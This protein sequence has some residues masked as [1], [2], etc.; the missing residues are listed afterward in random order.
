MPDRMPLRVL[1]MGSH[2]TLSTGPLKILLH[3]GVRIC[4]LIMA[5][6]PSRRQ[7]IDIN[8]VLPEL[9][10]PGTFA[11]S[12]EENPV[13]IAHR[14]LIPVYEIGKMKSPA[15]KKTIRACQPDL[16]LVSCFPMRIPDGLIEVPTLGCFNL[17][18]ALL[19]QFRGPDPLFW[20]F[21]HGVRQTGVTIHRMAK[22]IDAGDIVAQSI[23][24]IES[25]I[26]EV[27]LLARCAEVGGKLFVEV[28]TAL[29]KGQVACQP[30]DEERS[31]TFTWPDQR[32]WVITPDRPA[33]WAYQ[34]IKGIGQR[35]T[36][37]V[38]HCDGHRYRVK[39]VVGYTTSGALRG[40]IRM[41]EDHLWIQCS[42]GILHITGTGF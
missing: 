2:S 20:I 3:H 30:Q 19:P 22:R 26:S 40:P 12:S 23:W 7:A 35:P 13:Q 11:I 10:P 27:R 24:D 15:V 1:Y 38:L 6:S 17:H 21:Y 28:I 31:S 14:H 32:H 9:L 25:G 16:I 41:E 37:L 36:P 29:D 33:Q 39:E 5:A 42:P 34:F 4:A 18:P 8:P